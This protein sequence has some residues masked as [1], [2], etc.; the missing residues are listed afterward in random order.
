M[1]ISGEEG[2][3]IIVSGAWLMRG[4]SIQPLQDCNDD[5]NW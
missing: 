2:K 1:Q 4:D 5:A 3:E